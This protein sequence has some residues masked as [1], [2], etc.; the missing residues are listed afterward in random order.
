M[1]VYAY[2]NDNQTKQTM[3]TKITLFALVAMFAM[4][5]FS[6]CSK[7]DDCFGVDGKPNMEAQK[8]K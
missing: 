7:N 2:V 8:K 5:L 1:A 3:K 4:T 6:S